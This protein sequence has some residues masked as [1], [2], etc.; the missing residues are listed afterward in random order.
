VTVTFQPDIEI[1]SR[2]LDRLPSDA[3]K[4]IV[5]N[6][7]HEGLRKELR[8]LAATIPNCQ[9]VEL[10]AN[11]GL[12]AGAN[13]GAA[14]AAQRLPGCLLLLLDQDS[15]PQPGA[16][17]CLVKAYMTLACET[18]DLG[19]VGPRLVDENTGLDHGFHVPSRL[20]WPRRF[21][22]AG[23]P[24]EIV[25]INGSGT[26]VS[27]ELFMR[28]GGLREDFFID[29]VDTE[30]A[31]RVRSAGYRIYGA[32]DATFLHRMGERGVAFWLL[33]WRVWPHRSPAR[34]FFLFRNSVLLLRSSE[35]PIRWKV[36]APLKLV[37][38]LLVHALF[39]P[40]R[41]AQ[42]T[43]MLRGAVAGLRES[44]PARAN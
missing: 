35:V 5:D 32:P 28:M 22:K 10:S 12:A 30:W 8:R 44:P 13:R 31:F 40:H 14:E 24:I 37:L 6:A 43:N 1:V 38:T 9:L 2:Q 18:G 34:H 27:S 15:E 42:M 29:H 11:V 21:P 26:L 20:G 36:W 39:D 16:V 41:G 33:G 23:A 17:N 19:C 25:N 4:V 7:S 3:L